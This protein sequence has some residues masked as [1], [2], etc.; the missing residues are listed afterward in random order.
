MAVQMNHDDGLGGRPDAGRNGRRVDAVRLGIHVGEDRARADIA[1]RVR[2][3]YE[4]QGGNDYLVARSDPELTSAR[5]SAAVPFT[6]E[7]ASS[8]SW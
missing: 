5:W 1:H 3:G 8:A 2:R 7:T 6:V 4:R